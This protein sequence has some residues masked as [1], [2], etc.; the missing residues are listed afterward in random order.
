MFNFRK[1]SLIAGLALMA[2]AGAFA[3]T[4]PYEKGPAPTASSLEKAGSFATKSSTISASSVSGFGG[5]S[6]I[7]ISPGYT[8]Y[9]SSLAWL[10]PRLASH[11]FVVLI[12]ETTTTLDQPD[13]RGR[14]LKAAVN[15][16]KAQNTKSG[17]VLRGKIDV[18]RVAVGGHSMGGGGTL[19]AVRDNASYKA[20][21]ALAPYNLTK[22]FSSITV[23]TLIIGASADII[24]PDSSHS[25]PFYNS[26]PTSTPK[27]FLELNGS[28]HLFP[29]SD[30][31]TV[32]RFTVA[33]YKRWLD[34]DTRFTQFLTKAPSS[35]TA[36]LKYAGF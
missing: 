30:N 10:G 18:D 8:A 15:Y 12:I 29:Q 11:G 34:E 9:A 27:A 17:S 28:S 33:W 3:Q 2:T 7:A 26:I 36:S 4:N 32:S 14:Q 19:E 24:A 35:S 25:T 5:G 23:P 6:A 1:Y 20:G 22:S 16:L 31:A 21:V 13:S